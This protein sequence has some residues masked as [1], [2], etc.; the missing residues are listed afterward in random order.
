[1]RRGARRARHLL[2][3]ARRAR[4][5]EEALHLRI[6]RLAAA[7]GQRIGAGGRHRQRRRRP[8]PPRGSSAQ[9]RTGSH[10]AGTPGGDDPGHPP[11]SAAM[12]LDFFYH[13]RRSGIP[14]SVQEYLTLLETLRAGVMLPS[15]DDF[16]HLARMTLVKDETLFDRYDRAFAAFYGQVAALYP[17]GR[18]IP[19]EW[20]V[21]EFQKKLTPEEK[22]AL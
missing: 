8:S 18:D 6:P 7:A 5:E 21:K 9:E 13:L 4:P 16:Y 22:A 19:L 17:E 12:L 10:P 3:A 14:V 11:L 1:R 20:L 15:V 2:R